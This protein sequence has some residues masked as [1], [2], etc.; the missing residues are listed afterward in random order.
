MPTV[1]ESDNRKIGNTA[2]RGVGGPVGGGV[3]PFNQFGVPDTTARG[4]GAASS[5]KLIYFGEPTAPNIPLA[6]NATGRGNTAGGS[7]YFTAYSNLLPSLKAR[8]NTPPAG[9]SAAA[10][11]N[12]AGRGNFLSKATSSLSSWLAPIS[13]TPSAAGD[14]VV[15]AHVAGS[16]A[17]S[18]YQ[19]A[20][21]SLESSSNPFSSLAAAV[22]DLA[23]IDIPALDSAAMTGNQAA[24]QS[25][26]SQ[27]AGTQGVASA[28]PTPPARAPTPTEAEGSPQGEISA[29]PIPP[30]SS[31]ANLPAAPEGYHYGRMYPIPE[32][33]DIQPAPAGYTSLQ[34]VHF[35]PGSGQARPQ[36]F[37]RVV[38]PGYE[39]AVPNTRPIMQPEVP[40]VIIAVP[41]GW[42]AK[43]N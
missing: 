37:Y 34:L 31:L 17:P 13:T 9:G 14:A 32:G 21:A 7:K 40:K 6:A 2:E 4:D 23:M 11:A 33:E 10:P 8:G 19:G 35:E 29:F 18:G 42:Q 12:T 5:G 43:E 16:G 3:S 22:E 30:Y 39:S 15:S 1:V 36:I 20:T 25:T 26:G 24:G 41:E 38:A 27:A 28:P